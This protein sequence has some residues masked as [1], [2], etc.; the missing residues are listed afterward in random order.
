MRKL[1]LFVLIFV[2]VLSGLVVAETV[3]LSR[4]NRVDAYQDKYFRVLGDPSYIYFDVMD[5]TLDSRHP[6]ENFGASKTLRLEPGQSNVI[7]LQFGQ[8]NRAIVRG[9]RITDVKLILHPVPGRYT[10]DV[11]IAIYRITSDW[12]DG[13]ADGKPMYWTATYNAAF[14]SSRGNAVLWGKPGARGASDRLPKPS[15][16]TNTSVGYNKATNTW[17]ITGPGLLKDV[18]YWFGKQYRNYG[19]AIEMAEPNTAR[20]QVHVFSSDTM[21]KDLHPE[22]VVT[23]EPLLNEG[24]RKG[25]DLNVTFISRTP[26]YLRYHDDGVHSYERKRYR[27]DNPGIMKYPVNKDTKKWPDKGELMTYTAHIKNSGFDTYSG[28]V[29]WVWTYN[30][31]VIAK[32]TDQVTLKPEEEITKAIK[33]PW[34]GDMSDIRDE[35]LMF[36]VDPY[37][38]INEITKNNNAEVKYV[39]ARTW[40]YWVERSAYE[41][42]K[43]FL[44][45]Y[46]SYSWEDYL[47]FHEQV[48]NETYL[49]KSR[50][51]DLA[52]DGCLQRISLDDFEIVPDGKLGGGI[53][54]YEDKPDFH[55]DGEWGSEWVKGEAL[56]NP[57]VVKNAQNFIRF[58][59]IFL[60]GSLLHECAHQVLGAFDIYWSNIEPSDPNNPNGKCK[61][62]DGGEYYITRGSMYGY[63]GLMG[64]ASTQQN[65]HYCEGNGLFE[66]HSVMGFNSDLPYRNGFYGEWQYDLPRQV[67]V[68]LLAADGSPIPEAKVK[69]WQ[70]SAT[71]IV[72]K[73]VVAE[74]LKAD[75]NG[76]LKLPD[77]DS[78]EE[79]D[80]TVATGHTMLKKNPFGRIEVVG[81]NTVLLLKIEGFGQKDYRF[82]KIVDLNEEYW[83]G[84]RD[85]CIFDVRTQIT[86]G[87][88]DWS[89]NI[90]S[91]RNV[92]ST[93]NPAD[94]AK[95]VDNDVNT[96]WIGGAAPSGSYIQIDLG[97]NPKPVGAIRLIQNGSHG[98][99]FQRFKIEVSD[100]AR[101]RSGVTELN[102]Q[103]PDSFALAMT[104]DKDV[105]PQNTAVRW[106]TYGVRPTSAR[107]LRITCLSDSDG[108]AM[109]EI[110]VFPAVTK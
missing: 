33:L 38:K 107:Y 66:L 110:Q 94:A 82:I 73:N 67:F 14:S 101:F 31:K 76:I 13:G 29:D 102:R 40:K 69:I 96:T 106:I 8:L 78:G 99:F 18:A 45:H 48:W 62:K 92:Q 59:R 39:K 22:L 51:D 72:D 71:Q 80:Y 98:W 35:K 74:G 93:L 52:P 95:L 5:T 44:T 50:Y 89:T 55:F 3:H 105:D 34:K 103:Y 75:A 4:Y 79:S 15:L 32:G 85:K 77:Q 108:S 6:S 17:V 19:W 25:V 57:D 30:G 11:K 68:R 88:V 28:A 10:K 104:N 47:K 16:V 49:D 61:V 84:N 46:G 70:F 90:A 83:R 9:S 21:E 20:G 100:D 60:E 63:A 27:D 91:G 12:R 37:D 23:Y 56:N 26:R 109:S 86:P 53:H 2:F 87:I 54:R 65:E 41:Y 43:N 24:T 81:T 64:G 97:E 58:T 42:A 7:L 1:L 36:E